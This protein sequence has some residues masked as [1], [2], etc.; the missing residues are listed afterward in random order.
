MTSPGHEECALLFDIDGT[1]T[2]STYHHALAW[3]RAFHRL[4]VGVPLYR[5]H[6][7]IGMG[8]DKLVAHVA[9][10]LVEEESGDQLRA[11]WRE[12]YLRIRDGVQPL[13]GAAELVHRVA[14]AGFRVALASSG[15]REFAAEAVA[16]LGIVD[17]LEVLT[18]AEDVEGSKPEPDLVGETI[19]RL[20]GVTHAVL[21]GD[22]PYDVRAAQRAGIGCVGLRSG[23]YSEA[24]LDEA[25]A[26]LVVDL[27]E[28]LLDLDWVQHC[29][30][31][32]PP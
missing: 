3:Q 15:E 11:A 31:I 13:A 24:E 8:G 5:I 2:D 32:S 4:G 23:G 26:L 16:L 7:T 25:G 19:A 1:L 29:T 14:G 6:R 22:T 27:P 20:E 12:Q 30:P 10:E 21:V 18:T 9:G 17:D 28:D